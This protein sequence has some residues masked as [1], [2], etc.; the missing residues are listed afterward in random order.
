MSHN[1][2]DLDPTW[3]RAHALWL[4][5]SCVAVSVA[6]HPWPLAA[7]ALLSFALFCRRHASVWRGRQLLPNAVTA[8][9]LVGI[10]ASLSALH[11]S[12]AAFAI[13]LL[14]AWALD[15]VDGLLA[16]RLHAETAFGALWDTEVDA[17]LVL[18]ASVE[19]WSSGTL[20]VWV[21]LGGVLRYTYVLCLA[22][23]PPRDGALPRSQFARYAFGAIVLALASALL[24]PAP[25]A[26]AAAGAGTAWLGFSFA[27][28][29]WW[30][31]GKRRSSQ[32]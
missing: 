30:L 11:G 1:A 28:S 29:F 20:G 9:R 19:L 7:A 4:L 5:A 14:V 17:F 2:E 25:F 15:G 31:Y 27:R 6:A 21:L 22:A 23:L 24:L 12:R 32:P 8:L 18:S 26:A 13:A 3:T 10:V 16:R